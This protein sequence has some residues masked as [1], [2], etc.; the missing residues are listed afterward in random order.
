MSSQ[1]LG[2]VTSRILNH[3]RQH[4]VHNRQVALKRNELLG[5]KL[6][7]NSI[8]LILCTQT[9]PL[10]T[11]EELRVRFKM[12]EA[13]RAEDREKLRD[14]DRLKSE[15]AQLKETR[16][17]GEGEPSLLMFLIS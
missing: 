15:L 17:S 4:C 1:K 7:F 16:S 9:V 14:L 6:V 12:L 13:K 3:H 8:A 5:R 10:K 2:V 11:H